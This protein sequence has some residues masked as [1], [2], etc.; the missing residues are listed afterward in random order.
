MV[1]GS[2]YKGK[3]REGILDLKDAYEYYSGERGI[4]AETMRQSN[5]EMSYSNGFFS[6]PENIYNN[7]KSMYGGV[8]ND[9]FESIDGNHR[10]DETI[11]LSKVNNYWLVFEHPIDDS[12]LTIKTTFFNAIYTDKSTGE[13]HNVFAF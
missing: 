6:T 7:A 9:L 2:V 12:N 4:L 8:Q 10:L 13:T 1:E 3:S 5:Q 11:N